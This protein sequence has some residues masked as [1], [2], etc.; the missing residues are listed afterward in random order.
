M[1]VSSYRCSI[2]AINHPPTE[3]WTECASCGESTDRMA[4]AQPNITHEE[5]MSMRN[6]RL[7]DE[8]LEQEGRA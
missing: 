5:A 8:Y 4:H 7:F 3:E 1:G 2:C 6:H